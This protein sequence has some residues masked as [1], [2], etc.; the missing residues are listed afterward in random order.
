VREFIYILPEAFLALTLAFVVVGEITYHGEKTRLITLTALLGLGSAL[1]QALIS[2]GYGSAQ[3]FAKTLSMDGL[4]FFFRSFFILLA[5]ISV[6]A[7]SNSKEL[8][9]SRRTEYIAL[10]LA[11]TIAMSFAASSADLLLTFLSLQLVNIVSFFLAGYGKRS[12]QANEAGIKHM[13]FSAISGGLLIYGMVIIFGFSRSLNIYEIHNIIFE[14]AL[15]QRAAAVSF[16][17]IF[18]ALSFQ[19][20]AFPMY[21]WAP[22]VLNGAPT[23][24]ASFLAV[25]S[26]VS[27][28]AVLIRIIFTLFAQPAAE[29]SGR[30]QVMGALNWPSVLALVSGLSMLIGV[31][32]ALRQVSAKRMIACLLISQTGALLMGLLVL[33]WV[34]V[35]ALLYNLVVELFAVSG[36]FYILSFLINEVGS[37]RTTDLRGMLK[38]AAPECISLIL[39]ILCLI[40][41]PPMPGFIGKFALIGAA[42]GQGW[43]ILSAIAVVSMAISTFAMSRLAFHLVGDFRSV[44]KN[45]I[46]FSF[47]RRSFMALLLL[48]LLLTGV[49]AQQILS[50]AAKSI[51]FILW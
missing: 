4:T 17:L 18:V 43:T 20:G 32:L 28:F 1:I 47:E 46:A 48:P 29:A 24:A 13:I 41:V 27:G 38:W 6:L 7:L 51:V 42:A 31:F 3:I 40:G 10:L 14:T 37:D 11:A 25:G 30:W 21:F 34:G 50:W 15:N 19:I 45:K 16:T 23:P 9:R 5:M 2:F 26:R 44:S 8:A 39:F 12:E 36:I 33:D 22:D 49:F 35:A